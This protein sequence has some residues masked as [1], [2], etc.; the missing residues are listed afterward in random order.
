VRQTEPA[1]LDGEDGV[2][3]DDV[4]VAGGDQR[5]FLGHVDRKRREACDNRGKRAFVSRIEVLDDDE[6]HA[7]IGGDLRE[8]RLERLDPTGRS[9]N[10]DDQPRPL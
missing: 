1:V 9:A 2:W 3:R 5:P 10:P 6:R 8:E 4:D 7:D